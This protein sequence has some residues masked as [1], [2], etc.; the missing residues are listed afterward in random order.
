MRTSYLSREVIEAAQ[1]HARQRYPEESC[2]LVVDG[3]YWPAE[4]VC[5][6]ANQHEPGNADCGC[7]LCAFEIEEQFYLNAVQTGELQAILHSHP[8]GPLFPSQADMEGQLN[9]AVPW[10]IIGCSLQDKEWRV[11]EPI[12]WG[13]QLGVAPI[14]GRQ[15][16]HGVYDCYSLV[17]DTFRLGRE[18]LAK[19]GL[20]WPFD[21][22]ELPE[23]P[24]DDNWWSN[25][26]DLYAD[27]LK[28]NGFKLISMSDVRPGDGFLFKVRSD[29]FNHAGLLLGDGCILHHMPNR[30]S[31]R[32]PA[33]IWGR[34][35]DVWVRYEGAPV[36]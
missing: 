11:S 36:A 29:K 28:K 16:I 34:A 4:N 10:G 25:G 12:M 1:E 27:G 6:S 20:A 22:I 24:R 5:R 15:F 8:N 23:V 13:D 19:Q 21:P 32:E 7:K 3:A 18:E 2:G 33:S 30:L 31:R 17:R 14:L 9:T 26:K 35:A